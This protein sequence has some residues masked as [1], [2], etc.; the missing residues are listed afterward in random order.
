MQVTIALGWWIAPAIITIG[1]LFAATVWAAK[2]CGGDDLFGIGALFSVIG[3]L[4]A[5]QLSVIAW[6]IWAVLT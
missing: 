5:T 6:L 1:L 3:Y 4:V 2:E